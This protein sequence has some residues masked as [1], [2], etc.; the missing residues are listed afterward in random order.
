MDD[1]GDDDDDDVDDDGKRK[2][3][4]SLSGSQAVVL[5]TF[6]ISVAGN[7]GQTLKSFGKTYDNIVF[8]CIVY[9]SLYFV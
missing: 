2:S 4:L 3:N 7:L 6:V 5:K 8:L 9:Y 1:D